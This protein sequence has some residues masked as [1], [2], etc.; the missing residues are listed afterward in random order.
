MRD[1][2]VNIRV[3]FEPFCNISCCFDRVTHV[4]DHLGERP[5]RLTVYALR[6]SLCFIAQASYPVENNFVTAMLRFSFRRFHFVVSSY[7]AQSCCPL[8]NTMSFLFHLP[9]HPLGWPRIAHPLCHRLCVLLCP[10]TR[11]S[12]P[13]EPGCSWCSC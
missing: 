11:Q 7:P 5:P 4:G 3:G 6:P 10:A 12:G 13:S 9:N 8:T 1:L 2:D